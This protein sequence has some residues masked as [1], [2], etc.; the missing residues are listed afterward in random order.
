VIAKSRSPFAGCGF[1]RAKKPPQC[2]AH[3]TRAQPFLF[4]HILFGQQNGGR[5]MLRFAVLEKSDDLAH[6]GRLASAAQTGLR[7]GLLPLGK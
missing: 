1:R 5:D 6:V 4:F 7:Q 2:H 3:R